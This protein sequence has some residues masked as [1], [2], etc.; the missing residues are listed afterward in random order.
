MKEIDFSEKKEALNDEMLEFIREGVKVAGGSADIHRMVG[1][2][3]IS[4][5]G[6]E[7]TKEICVDEVKLER[8][9]LRF[10][11]A[12]AFDEDIKRSLASGMNAHISKPIEPRKL[13]QVI[14]QYARR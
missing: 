7:S 14:R 6:C 5:C 8:G 10:H 4:P 9:I 11:D 12:N 2:V 1:Y 13:E 3:I